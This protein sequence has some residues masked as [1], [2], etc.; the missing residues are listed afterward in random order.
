MEEL[1]EDMTGACVFSKL[2]LRDGCHQI[3]L[4]EE[5]RYVTT[6]AHK[7]ASIDISDYH[8]AS[9]LRLKLFRMSCN[10]H[11]KVFMAFVT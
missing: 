6:F 4:E 5:S 7:K 1:M 8:S 11:F 2:D 9:P 3:E 10:S